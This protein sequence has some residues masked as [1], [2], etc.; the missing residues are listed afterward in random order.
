MRKRQTT[1]GP[2]DI[3]VAKE[4]FIVKYDGQMV[5]VH[6]GV[7]RVRAGHPLTKGRESLFEPLT[8]DYDVEQASAAPGEKRGA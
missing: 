4:S 3:L 2:T 5:T 6:Q 1:A 8:V 7:T